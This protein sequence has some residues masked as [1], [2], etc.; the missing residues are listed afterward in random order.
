V[1]F[2]PVTADYKFLFRFERKFLPGEASAPG[3]VNRVGTFGNQPVRIMFAN[4][5][6]N[7]IERAFQRCGKENTCVCQNLRQRGPAFNERLALQVLPI[8]EQEIEN[9]V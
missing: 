8:K 4:G 1:A 7:R 6:E 3:L 9:V 2:G 5:L